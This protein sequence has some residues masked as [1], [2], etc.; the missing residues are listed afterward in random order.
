[1]GPIATIA[2]APAVTYVG[3]WSTMRKIWAEEGAWGFARGL[4]PRLIV[5]TPSMAISWTTYEYV[6]SLLKDY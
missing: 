6:K 4:R 2:T 1:M 5:H 3:M